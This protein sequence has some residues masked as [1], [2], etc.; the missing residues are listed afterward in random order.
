V[1]NKRTNRTGPSLGN[2]ARLRQSL[3]RGGAQASEPKLGQKRRKNAP[4][5]RILKA[6]SPLPRTIWKKDQIKALKRIVGMYLD[7]AENQASRQI[8][9]RIA[10]WVTKLDASPK[11]NECDALNNARKVS[12]EVAKQLS[13]SNECFSI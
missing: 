3:L 2:W 8:P 9:M 13:E 6:E 12:H 1:Q 4:H 10:D 11:F 5:G 7:Y